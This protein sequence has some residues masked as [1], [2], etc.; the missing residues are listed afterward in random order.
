MV[1]WKINYIT[2]GDDY[3]KIKKILIPLLVIL[4]MATMVAF[5]TSV[6]LG[7]YLSD[8]YFELS[9]DALTLKAGSLVDIFGLAKTDSGIIVGDGTNFV[10]E[11][12]ATARTSLGLGNVENLKV[13]LDATEAPAAATDD[14]TLGYAVGSRWVDITNDKEYVCLDNTD[15]AAVWTE[16]TGGGVGG[17]T[18]L[19]EF[20]AQTAFSVFYSDTD[21]DVTELALGTDGQ[22]LTSAGVDVAPAFEDAGG[23]G[24]TNTASNIGAEV[25]IFKQKTVA[26]L[27]F[28]TLKANSDKMIITTDA[29]GDTID[30]GPGAIDRDTNYSS[31]YTL[32]QKGNP[33]NLAGFITSI[34]MWASSTLAGCKVASFHNV[35]GTNFTAIDVVTIGEVVSGSKQTFTEDSEGNPIALEIALGDYIGVYYSSGSLEASFSGGDGWWSLHSDATACTDT[36]FSLSATRV[37]SIYATGITSILD[38][39]RFDVVPAEIPLDTLGSPTDITTLDASTTAHGLLPKL[40]NDDTKFLDGT[41]NWVVPAGGASTFVALTDTP[42]DYT[43]QAGKY[44]KV[45]DG[46]TALEFGTPAGAG[47]AVTTDPLSQFAATTSAELAGVIS[48]EIGTGKAVF[49]TSPTLVTPLLG[50]PTSGVVTNLTGVFSGNLSMDHTLGSDEDYSG[51]TDSAPVGETVAIGDLLYYDWTDVEWKKAKADAFGTTPAMRIA[52]EVKDNGETCL[53]LVQGYIRDDD[54]FDF[55]ASRVYLNDDT[56]GTCDDTAPAESGDQIQLVG[57]AVSADILWF[58]PSIDIGEI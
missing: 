1:Y 15:G 20:V 28:R 21:G 37:A 54:A 58:N 38:Y 52:L 22:V 35:S 8:D 19:T 29:A 36:T 5:G 14:V 10:L 44:A 13:K 30:I 11:T 7:P 49:A 3:M 32:I 24:E 17:Y 16:T 42:A 48:D 55:G 39:V 34:E 12:G 31:N 6:P 45:N 25:E 26:D 4:L 51:I 2:Q 41:G 43:D 27:E 50:T 33:A 56:A 46:E 57:I 23:A 53:M 9:D 40:P 18:N 47:D